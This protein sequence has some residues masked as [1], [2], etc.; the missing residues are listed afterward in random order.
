MTKDEAHVRPRFPHGWM[1]DGKFRVPENSGPLLARESLEFVRFL[2][3]GDLRVATKTCGSSECH[4]TQTNA[5]GKSMMTHGAMLWGAALYNNGGFPIKDANFGESYSA[6]GAPQSLIQ[7]PQPS[8]DQRRLKGILSFLD[9][10]P[11]W[12]ISQ[13]GNVLRVFERGAG[14]TDCLLRA[15]NL[16]READAN[17]AIIGQLAG[18]HYGAAGLP[19]GWLAR[20]ALRDRIEALAEALWAAA[21][22]RGARR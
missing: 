4:S 10:L 2:N 19:A 22:R 21:V 8:D 15:A 1:R 18:A 16:G 7:F 9:P 20:L 17:A 11:R 13:P 3:P 12:E 6:N 5:V 14:L